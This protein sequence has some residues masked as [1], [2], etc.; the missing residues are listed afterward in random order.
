MK[1]VLLYIRNYFLESAGW[2]TFFSVVIPIISAIFSGTFIIEITNETGL[3]WRAF[4]IA[5]SF[6]CL[7][8]IVIVI[9]FYNK[10]M[11]AYECKINHFRD[12]DFCMAYM[13]S[14]CLP[15]AAEKYKKRIRDGEVGELEKAM[16]ETKRILK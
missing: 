7:L 1:K 15:E 8:L 10:A 11:Y 3:N 16:D 4:Y 5:K 12:K 9:Y 6:Y 2:K 14:K 13:R